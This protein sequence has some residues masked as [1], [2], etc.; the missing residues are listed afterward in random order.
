MNEGGLYGERLG[1]HL[2]S[3]TP[4][5]T[6]NLSSPAAGLASSGIRFYTTTVHL[7]IDSDLDAPLGIELTAPA[8]TVARVMI[9]INGYQYGKYVPHIGP[10][11]KFPV[12]PKIINNRKL[13][14]VALSL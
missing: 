12:P 2:P 1:W 14:T 3:F 4:D 7:N 9:W 13:N 11:T 10:Q 5:S 6:F 8:G